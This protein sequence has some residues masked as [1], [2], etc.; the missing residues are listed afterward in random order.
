[1][2]ELDA[3][4]LLRPW[5]LSAV[6]AVVILGYFCAPFPIGLGG[7]D[8][9]VERTLLAGLNQRGAVVP[10][11]GRPMLASVLAAVIIAFA[12]VGPALERDSNQ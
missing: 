10:G 12:L 3:I 2:I 6:P 5:W 8:K 1:M 7:W 11:T 9:A 4:A